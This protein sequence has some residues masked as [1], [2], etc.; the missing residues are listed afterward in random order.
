MVVL[1]LHSSCWSI[2]QAPH[3]HRDSPPSVPLVVVWDIMRLQ[4]REGSGKYIVEAGKAGS[5][6]LGPTQGREIGR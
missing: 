3:I 2:P 1:L 6:D 4:R 5:D